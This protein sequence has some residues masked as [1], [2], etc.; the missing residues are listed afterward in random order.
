MYAAFAYVL[1][2]AELEIMQIVWDR[3]SATVGEVRAAMPPARPLAYVTIKTIM[4]R[5]ASK[6]LLIRIPRRTRPGYTYAAVQ[7]HADLLAQAF[8]KLCADLG[9]NSAGGAAVL[10][11]IE[12]PHA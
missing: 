3:A 2:P 1:P 8:T 10:Q 6:R 7:S 9:M 5:L 12:T 4:D 11:T